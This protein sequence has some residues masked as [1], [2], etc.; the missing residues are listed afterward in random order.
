[1]YDEAGELGG[2]SR[3]PQAQG[4]TPSWDLRWGVLG[5]GPWL[6]PVLLV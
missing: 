6:S 3:P 4:R 5:V 1:M 2:A